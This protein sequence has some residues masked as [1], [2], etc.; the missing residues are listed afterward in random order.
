MATSITDLRVSVLLRLGDPAS[1]VWSTGEIE[2][3][4]KEGYRDFL[5]RGQFFWLQATLGDVASQALYTLPSDLV[6]LERATWNKGTMIPLRTHDLAA[7]DPDFLTATGEPRAFSLDGDGVVSL[8]KFPIP[9][10]NGA[11]DLDTKIEYI[12]QAPAAFTHLTMPEHYVTHVRHYAMARALKR[13]SAGQD[14]VLSKHFMSRYNLGLNRS[15]ARRNRTLSWSGPIAGKR[16]SRDRRM[17][18]A[19][20]NIPDTITGYNS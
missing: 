13:E 11:G 5:H 15:I 17:R 2:D 14:L 20:V 1:D 8:R 7:K 18:F 12:A 10:V 9:T 16:R 4:I 6:Y 3:Y 19:R